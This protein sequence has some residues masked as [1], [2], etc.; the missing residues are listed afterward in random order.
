MLPFDIKQTC[1]MI[2]DGAGMI[3]FKQEW[4]DNCTKQLALVT[5]ADHPLHGSSIQRLMGTDP[6]MITPQAQAEGLRAPEI[7][8]TTRAAREA[9]RVASKVVAKPSPWTTIKQ[10]ESESFT[11]FVDCLQSAL[12]ASTLPSEAKGPVL[13]ECLRQQ[14]NSATKDILR[15]LPQGSNT[16]AMIRHVAKE[17]HLAPIQAAVHTAITSVMACTKC[18]QGGHVAIN[19]PWL[20]HPSAAAPP[21]Q[22]KPRGPC[23][24]CGR[25]GHVAKECRSKHQGNGRGRG[26]PGRIQPPPTGNMQRPSYSNPQWGTGFPC[27]PLPTPQGMSNFAAQ[28]VVQLNPPVPQEYHKQPLGEEV[29]GWLWP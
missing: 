6:T 20:G 24:A 16:A 3:L 8:T 19:C 11:Q 22:G 27:P 7:M 9:I 15:S 12:D 13:A 21:C 29:P 14:C 28:P 10:S 26:Q 23:W 17:E 2:F 4:E 5:G 1:R 18:G 25:K